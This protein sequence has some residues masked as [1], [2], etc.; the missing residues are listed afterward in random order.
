MPNKN[1]NKNIMRDTLNYILNKYYCKNTEIIRKDYITRTMI[2]ILEKYDLN[3]KPKFIDYDIFKKELKET[4]CAMTG[5]V[6]IN[7]VN[8]IIMNIEEKDLDDG[9]N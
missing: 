3:L 4:I 5:K 7:S 1:A 2:I 6:N 8:E 9:S